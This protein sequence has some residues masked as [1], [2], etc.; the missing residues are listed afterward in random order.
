MRNGFI[1][2]VLIGVDNQES[3]QIGGKL[4]E[5]Y[6]TITQEET[7]K[8][9]VVKKLVGKLLIQNSSRE[10]RKCSSERVKLENW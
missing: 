10:I 8:L 6:E 7:S 4:F 1:F 3:V 2:D 5:I 9:S